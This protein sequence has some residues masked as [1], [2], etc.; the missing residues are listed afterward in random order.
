[1]NL[2]YW[3]NVVVL[4]GAFIMSILLFLELFAVDSLAYTLG[5]VPRGIL[6]F[7]LI[8]LCVGQLHAI[9][10]DGM[11]EIRLHDFLRDF[12][13]FGL[14]FFTHLYIIRRRQKQEQTK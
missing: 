12:G 2:I 7:V 1:M 9:D 3:L 13:Q 10:G 4:F 11:A 14:L 8:M 6:K 5:T